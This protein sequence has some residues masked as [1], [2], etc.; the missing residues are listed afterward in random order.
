M[1]FEFLLRQH[2]NVYLI[3]NLNWKLERIFNSTNYLRD[4]QIYKINYKH[5][6]KVKNNLRRILSQIDL[7]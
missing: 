2:I 5:K 7:I 6:L 1:G 3:K 4:L